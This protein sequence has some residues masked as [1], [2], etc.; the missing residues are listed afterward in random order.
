MELVPTKY[1]TVFY[2]KKKHRKKQDR[3]ASH[4]MYIKHKRDMLIHLSLL[5]K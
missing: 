5:L 2:K 1:I 3:Q 4:I